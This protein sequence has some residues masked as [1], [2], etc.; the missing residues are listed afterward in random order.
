M[1]RSAEV[2]EQPL[3]QR[4]SLHLYA[5]VLTAFAFS[6]LLFASVLI[7]HRGFPLDDSWIHQ[8]VARN[9]ADYGSLGYLPHQRSSGST[10]LLWTIVLS[11]KYVWLASVSPI[12]YTVALN[13]LC[14]FAIGSLLLRAA[15]QDGVSPFVAGLWA[16]APAFDGNFV[17]LAFTGME[18][19]LFV[20]LSLASILT[21]LRLETCKTQRPFWTALAGGLSM[22]LLSMTRPEGIVLVLTLL[23]AHIVRYRS[24]A[25][26]LPYLLAASVACCLSAIPFGLNLISSRSLLPLTFK[27]REWLYF[28][29]QGS[30]LHLRIELLQEWILRPF[31]MV[32][33]VDG[34]QIHG[35]AAHAGFVMMFLLIAGI[36]GFG[37][38]DLIRRRRWA[39]SLICFWGVLH[40]LLYAVILPASGHGGRYQSFYLLL[41]LPLFMMGILSL[42]RN[43]PSGGRFVAIAVLLVIGGCSLPLW[44]RVLISGIDH[45]NGTHGAVASWI[46]SNLP[47]DAIAV[48]DIGRIGYQRGNHPE[49]PQIVDLGGLTDTAYLPYLLSGRVPT[50]LNQHHIEYAVF[51]TEENGSSR[52]LVSLNFQGNSRV[53]RTVIFRAC[54]D[55]KRRGLSWIETRNAS[56][57][58]E[59]DKLTYLNNPEN[60][61]ESTPIAR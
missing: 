39:M 53:V 11:I 42:L 24:K 18:H 21:W 23:V 41:T 33:A 61:K 49:E 16:A 6:I 15:I 38:F 31:K 22:G 25:F 58:Q 59:V 35:V 55:D 54:S 1:F 5:A 52:F 37:L 14:L 56:P 17:W 29:G 3:P 30:A 47:N 27:G 36:S 13:T 45:I 40:S 20:A 57:C 26:D 50:Y 48:F 19:L 32:A 8:S 7:T 2:Q 9:L 60:T 34:Q 43:W 51:P 10:S 12:I 4:Y 46:D 28:T 44:R